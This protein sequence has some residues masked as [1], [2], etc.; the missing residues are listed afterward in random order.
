MDP[1]DAANIYVA[2][3]CWDTAP[4]DNWIANELRRDTVQLRHYVD[5]RRDLLYISL[6]ADTVTLFYTNPLGAR[7][8]QAVT[9][10][11]TLYPDWNPVWDVGTGTI[12]WRLDGRDEDSLQVPAIS[13][14][15]V[16]GMEH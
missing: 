8:D 16:S 1:F 10:E 3:R 7:A 2:C 9:D 4:P 12:Q 5:V 15:C 14:R 11:G 13:I 6:T